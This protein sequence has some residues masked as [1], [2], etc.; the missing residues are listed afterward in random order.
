MRVIAELPV[1]L[2]RRA[3]PEEWDARDVALTTIP[4]GMIALEVDPLQLSFE[5]KGDILV[6]S[7]AAEKG[8]RPDFWSILDAQ[9][10]PDGVHPIRAYVVLGHSKTDG[11]PQC[12]AIKLT[13]D[14]DE[15]TG[16]GDIP[17]L[18]FTM[19]DLYPGED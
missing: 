1:V 17:F 2:A 19:A 9:L 7:L 13:G 12:W 14:S 3:S 8:I 4:V 11:R 18:P 10:S 16:Y 5:R 15:A 6:N